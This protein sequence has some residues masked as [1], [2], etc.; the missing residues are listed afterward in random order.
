[1]RLHEIRYKGDRIIYEIG[2]Q[3]ALAHYAGNDPVQSGTAYLDTFY[4][5]GPYAFELIGGYDCPT[6]ASYLNSTFY[7]EETTHTHVNSICIFEHDAGYPISRH[8]NM[9]YATATKN[10]FLTVRCMPSVFIGETLD[11]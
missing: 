7:T 3:E 5:F 8:T 10:I 2:L 1:V 11:F 4:G 6:Y 9:D